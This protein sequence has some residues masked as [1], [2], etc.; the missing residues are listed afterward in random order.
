MQV[1]VV[2]MQAPAPY[3]APTPYVTQAAPVYNPSYLSYS[4]GGSATVSYSGSSGESSTTTYY[5]G[6]SPTATYYGGRSGPEC[7]VKVKTMMTAMV[8]MQMSSS[9]SLMIEPMMLMNIALEE[10]KQCHLDAWKRQNPQEADQYLQQQQN[11][12]NILST[13]EEVATATK[14]WSSMERVGLM[15][16]AYNYLNKGRTTVTNPGKYTLG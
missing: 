15:M 10:G 9:R 3:Q 14:S 16:F 6:G 7:P 2:D 12:K 13:L 5:G 8:M 1:H 11:Q 4:G